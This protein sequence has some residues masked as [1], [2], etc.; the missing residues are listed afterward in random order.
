MSDG[1][2]FDAAAVPLSSAPFVVSLF[3]SP[4][5]F[6]LFLIEDGHLD[7]HFVGFLD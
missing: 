4:L 3:S 1:V 7:C 2:F 6:A 5:L